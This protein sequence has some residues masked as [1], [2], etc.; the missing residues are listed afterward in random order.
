VARG[1]EIAG[2]Q[3]SAI[4]VDAMRLTRGGESRTLLLVTR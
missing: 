3:V 1:D 2:W 4:G